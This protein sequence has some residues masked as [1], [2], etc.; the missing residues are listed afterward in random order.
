[1]TYQTITQLIDSNQQE[2]KTRDVTRLIK[3]GFPSFD[4]SYFGIAPRE[5][6]I[7]GA[8]SGTGKTHLLL[9]I[10]LNAVRENHR[11]LF[12]SLEMSSEALTSR[13]TANL[14]EVSASRLEWGMLRPD[15]HNKKIEAEE[16]LRLYEDKLI[17]TDECYTLDQIENVVKE[18]T[19]KELKPELVV[20]D[21]VQQIQHNG[22]SEYERMNLAS[23]RLQ[24]LAKQYDVSFFIAS[25]ISNEEARAGGDS[26]IIGYKGSGAIA[27]SCDFGLWVEPNNELSSENTKIL[28]CTV[29]KARR[30]PQRKLDLRIDFPSG[31]VSE[32]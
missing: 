1:M 7:I 5:L 21:Y 29:K 4:Q 19:E 13:L 16:E 23:S 10:A 17:F 8:Y 25:Q 14:S 9:Q 15:E 11:V 12:L 2:A 27:A 20:L 30:G 26:K 32:A 22:L 31:R 6:W 18:L 24:Q 3:T 28:T